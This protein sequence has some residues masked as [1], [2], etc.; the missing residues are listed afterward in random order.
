MLAGSSAVVAVAAYVIMPYEG[1]VVNSQGD[2]VSYLDMVGVPTACWGTTG[3][4]LY[5][6]KIRAGKIYTQDE[7][8]KLFV[9]D[10]ALYNSYVKKHVKVELKPYEEVAY[11]SLVWNIGETAFKNSKSVLGRLN[12]GD[13]EGACRG[14]LDWNKATFSVKGAQ[15]QMKAGETCTLRDAKRGEY[16]CTVKGLTNRRLDEYKTCTGNNPKVN[17]ALSSFSAVKTAPEALENTS[18]GVD[19]SSTTKELSSVISPTASLPTNDCKWKF[20]NI[21]LRRT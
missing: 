8:E 4:D 11:T 15:A 13:H 1:K 2:H 19:E 10:L 6:D 16:L 12:S 3:K 7:C 9:R 21:C 17:A 18:E 20:F 14:I 5:G